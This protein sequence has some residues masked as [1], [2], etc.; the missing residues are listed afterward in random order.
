LRDNERYVLRIDSVINILKHP[1]AIHINY[2]VSRNNL[3]ITRLKGEG[4]TGNKI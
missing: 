3:S 4:D 1:V 2:P